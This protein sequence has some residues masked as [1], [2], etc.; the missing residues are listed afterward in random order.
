LASALFAP[1]AFVGDTPSEPVLFLAG[2]DGAEVEAVVAEL[3]NVSVEGGGSD[4]RHA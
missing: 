1:G 3:R 2:L 4:A